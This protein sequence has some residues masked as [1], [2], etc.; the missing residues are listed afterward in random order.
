MHAPISPGS[1]GASG[2]ERANTKAVQ[3]YVYECFKVK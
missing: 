1:D 3:K 2:E